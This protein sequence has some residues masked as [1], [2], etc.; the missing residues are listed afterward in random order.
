[1]ENDDLTEVEELIEVLKNERDRAIKE[2]RERGFNEGKKQVKHELLQAMIEN[3]SD[4]KIKKITKITQEEL[5][6]LKIEI[7]L[8]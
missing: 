8:K 5:E 7:K 6:N 1:M 2:A 4:D 3:I